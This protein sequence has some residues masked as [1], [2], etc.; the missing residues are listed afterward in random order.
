MPTSSS[1]K[2]WRPPLRPEIE[3]PPPPLP[4]LAR[5]CWWRSSAPAS[6]NGCSGTAPTSAG[7]GHPSTSGAVPLVAAGFAAEPSLG[8][9]DGRRRG[10]RLCPSL[11]PGGLLVQL[12]AKF[13]WDWGI[14]S[15]RSLPSRDW[16]VVLAIVLIAAERGFLEALLFGILAG[17]VIFAV[18]VSRIRV[19]RHQ[20]GLDE[21]ASSVIRSTAESALLAEHGAEV[22]VLELSGYLFFGSAY[23]VQERVAR[24]DRKSVV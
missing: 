5:R 1:A 19:I 10:G 8:C 21:R 11:R 15:R 3:L 14:R 20:F 22:Q 7:A 12:G 23:S 2:R 24:L 18:D 16:L 6:T 17:C 13:M 4:Q 9:A